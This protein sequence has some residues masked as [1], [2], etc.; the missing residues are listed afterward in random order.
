MEAV[1]VRAS[2]CCSCAFPENAESS[3]AVRRVMHSASAHATSGAAPAASAGSGENSAA[4]PPV[5]PA[6]ATETAAI[7]LATGCAD[8]VAGCATA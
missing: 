5:D 7:D 1:A 8:P 6:L 2:A 3:S 4:R